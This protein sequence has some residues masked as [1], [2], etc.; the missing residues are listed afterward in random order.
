MFV[1]YAIAN[2]TFNAAVGCRGGVESVSVAGEL[3]YGQR[4]RSGMREQSYGRIHLADY[5]REAWRSFG[6]NLTRSL[7]TMLG[8][9]IGTGAVIAVIAIGN[10]SQ[11][12]IAARING[13]GTNLIT[14]N[15]GRIRTAGVAGAAGGSSAL[16]VADADAIAG[17]KPE[18]AA[19]A[20]QLSQSFQIT[21]GAQNTNTSVIGTTPS[22]T[23]VNSWNVDEGSFFSNDDVSTSEPVAVIGQSTAETLFGNA[24]P[25]GQMIKINGVAFT[26]IGLM[27]DRSQSG[28]FDNNDQVFVPITTA[29]YRLIGGPSL[30]TSSV[31]SISIEASSQQAIPDAKTK[32]QNLLEQR[33]NISPNGTD[34]FSIQSQSQLLEVSSSVQEALTVFLVSIAAISLLVGGIGIMNIMLVSVTE[35]TREIGIRKAVGA[36]KR[37]ILGQFL[38][39][40]LLISL[41]GGLIGV[42]AG[43]IGALT[44]GH[45]SKAPIQVTLPPML[46]A[47][48]VSMAIGLFFG[49]YPAQRA[50]QLSPIEA[51][52][53]E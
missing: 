48:G 17:L 44:Y 25:L 43:P 32:I 30:E 40:A 13:L 45:F 31:R 47:A 3:S 51:L 2:V 22:Y 33:H 12:S 16:T 1:L 34:D 36:S 11:A 4:W 6:A 21:A 38:T 8:I 15:P 41:A 26:V 35:R 18:V 50:A 14:I 20:P 53:A 37:D 7:L 46:L 10:G 42:A 29:H 28:P 19:V 52:R 9:V 5:V 27:Q 49:V 24:D 39:E 23:T